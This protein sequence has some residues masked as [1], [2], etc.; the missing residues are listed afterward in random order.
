MLT[1][2]RF[3]AFALALTGMSTLETQLCLLPPDGARTATGRAW[4]AGPAFLT[5]TVAGPALRLR[6]T[7]RLKRLGSRGRF[8]ACPRGA[9]GLRRTERGLLLEGTGLCDDVVL[10]GV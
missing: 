1:D 4:A 10:G 5:G 6:I 9:A 7:T 3:P 8:A 2:R